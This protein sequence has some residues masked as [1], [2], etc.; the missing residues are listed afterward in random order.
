[1]VRLSYQ[2]IFAWGTVSKENSRYNYFNQAI[3]FRNNT[4]N[5]LLTLSFNFGKNFNDRF[6]EANIQN[7][8]I[9]LKQ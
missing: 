4:S 7:D 9:I 3:V 6:N 1:M 8:D 2:D 5:L